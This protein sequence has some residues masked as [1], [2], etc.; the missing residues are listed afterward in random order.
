MLVPPPPRRRPR[1]QDESHG[2]EYAVPVAPVV[3]VKV[4]LLEV[5]PPVWRRFQVP[6]NLTL[7]RLHAVLQTVMGWNPSPS[8]LFRVGDELF[9]MPSGDAAT[10]KDS[11]WTMLQHLLSRGAK[12]FSYEYQLGD[13]WAHMVRIEGVSEG[14]PANQIPICLAG[15]NPCPPAG[16]GGPDGYAR[17]ADA[18]RGLD[19]FD[20]AAV[21][22]AL[23]ALDV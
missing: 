20:L 2:R 12:A 8:H 15:E 14:N 5:V 21:N 17:T 11:R 4:T 3:R 10:V 22:E 19:S 6:A 23:A 18:D 1:S 9:G 7:R 16:C 13:F